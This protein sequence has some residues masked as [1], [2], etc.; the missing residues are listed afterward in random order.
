MF[1]VNIFY[2]KIFQ[3]ITLVMLSLAG[4]FGLT[5]EYNTPTPT[6]ITVLDKIMMPSNKS[7]SLVVIYRTDDGVIFDMSVSPST[8]ATSHIGESYKIK[9]RP[10]HVRHNLSDLIAFVIIP[11]F[12]VSFAVVGWVVFLGRSVIWLFEKKDRAN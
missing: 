1:N 9:V 5:A 10:S 2:S 3:L 8:Y 7:T 4:Y 6:P 12:M 11:I